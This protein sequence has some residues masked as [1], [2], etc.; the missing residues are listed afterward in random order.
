MVKQDWWQA[1]SVSKLIFVATSACCEYFLVEYSRNSRL[2]IPVHTIVPFQ[3]IK[4]Y[5]NNWHLIVNKYED[6]AGN[7]LKLP[8]EGDQTPTLQ[9]LVICFSFLD[10]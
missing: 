4:T 9:E 7:Y 10:H 2:V 8:K 6:Y 5:Q 3:C 1:T